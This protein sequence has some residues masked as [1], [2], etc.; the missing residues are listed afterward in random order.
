MQSWKEEKKPNS[1]GNAVQTNCGGNELRLEADAAEI[2]RR[3]QEDRVGGC[4]C[5]SEQEDVVVDDHHLYDSR[6]LQQF[7]GRHLLFIGSPFLLVN[8]QRLD[9]VSGHTLQDLE[10]I[11][12]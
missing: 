6:V 3:V 1:L 4:E 5:E 12:L 7:P 11:L 8:V 10:D 9:L 2:Y